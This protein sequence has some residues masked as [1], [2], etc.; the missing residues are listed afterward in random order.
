MA[1]G[2]SHGMNRM[3]KK[4]D[5]QLIKDAQ[6]CGCK[7]FT[8]YG[9]DTQRQWTNRIDIFWFRKFYMP[10]TEKSCRKNWIWFNIRKKICT[11]FGLSLKSSSPPNETFSRYV[12]SDFSVFIFR[13][14]NCKWYLVHLKWEIRV[15]PMMSWSEKWM[16][17]ETKVNV[18]GWK[19][20]STW[21][22]LGHLQSCYFFVC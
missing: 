22:R 20:M 15:T 2:T 8:R 1:N 4:V 19:M 10:A 13:W 16:K 6:L 9:D 5:D 11:N 17:L 3:Q 12:V 7:T 18:C 14:L 21:P